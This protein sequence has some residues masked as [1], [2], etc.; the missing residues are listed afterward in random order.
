MKEWNGSPLEKNTG[1]EL[2]PQDDKSIIGHYLINLDGSFHYASFGFLNIYGYTIDELKQLTIFDIIAPEDIPTVKGNIEDRLQKGHLDISYQVR[3]IRKDGRTILLGIHSHMFQSENEQPLLMGIIFDVTEQQE[4]RDELRKTNQNLN[5]FIAATPLALISL[6]LQANVIL[7]NPAAEEMFGWKTDEVMNKPLPTVLEEDLEK[8]QQSFQYIIQGNHLKNQEHKRKK[9]DGSIIDVS[10]STAPTYSNDG[11]I[12][13]YMAIVKDIS[14]RKQREAQ[15]AET[16]KELRDLKYALDAAATVS[17]TDVDGNILYVNDEFCRVSGYPREELI[18]KDHRLINSDFHP[19]DFFTRM[20]DRIKSGETWRGEVLNRTKNRTFWWA[21]VTII[22]FLNDRGEPYQFIAIRSDITERKTMEKAISQQ[23]EEL[24]LSEARFRSLVQNSHDMISILDKKGHFRYI[25]PPFENISGYKIES[26]IGTN[27]FDFVHPDE[28][29]QAKA[30]FEQFVQRSGEALKKEYRLLH[31][32]GSWVHCQITF[33]NLYHEKSINGIVCNLRD[34][35]HSRKAEEQIKYMAYYDH[36]TALPNR[37]L[38]EKQLSEEFELAKSS[39]SKLALMFLDLDSFK[40]INDSLG[41]ETG[42]KLIQETARRL[43]NGIVN[44][45]MVA[46]MG[47]DEFTVIIRNIMDEYHAREISQQVIQLFEDPFIIDN[48]EL[49]ITTS[50][51]VCIYPINANS[52]QELLKNADLAMYLAKERGKNKYQI[53]TST[54]NYGGNKF[55]TLQHDIRNALKRNEFFLNYQPIV[56]LKSSKLIGAEALIRWNH[57]KWGIVSPNEFIPSAEESGLI[58]KIGEW[59]LYNACRQAKTWQ[60]TGYPPIVMSVNF[61][62]LQF[63]QSDII[64]TIE[65]IL[66]KTRLEPRWLEIEIT[67]TAIVKNESHVLNKIEELK[68]IGVKIAIDDFGAGYSSLSYLK[69]F[70]VNTLKIDRSYINEILSDSENKEIV[71]TIIQLA[72]KMNIKTVAE[73]VETI[74]QLSVLLEND[75][76]RVQGYLFSKPL[77]SE[78][79]AEILKNGVYCQGDKILKAGS[80]RS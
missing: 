71:S 9:K 70:K 77:I 7:W 46:R 54:Q 48:Q 21:D 68:D 28:L 26:L 79:F 23:R 15:I 52:P 10:I 53:Y 30:E 62:M 57:P 20:W 44:K 58:N 74:E 1:K 49:S 22:P 45:V 33:T 25:N 72:R 43:Q 2:L 12:N 65:N 40:L 51:G 14:E 31:A 18:G 17:I 8:W 64:E 78:R 67:E 61:S 6:N 11:K 69:K 36:L 56:E 66:T 16:L 80:V 55:Y 19:K 41:H 38:F 4:T 63:L 47:G 27:I 32:D 73:G 60:E 5:A 42:D 35:T 13:G 37:R 75:C 59:V 34:I 3:G 50:I 76:D 39:K 24:R 29:A